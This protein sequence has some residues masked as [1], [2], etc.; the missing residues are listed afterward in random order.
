MIPVEEVEKLHTVLI[1]KF[2]GVHG[3]RDREMLISALSRP[4]QTFEN[5]HNL[6]LWLH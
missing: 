3:I 2:G 1:N 6:A 5:G 4:F